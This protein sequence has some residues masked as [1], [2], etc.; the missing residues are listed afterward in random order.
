MR[1]IK[2]L[3]NLKSRVA[4]ITGAS[5]HLGRVI[6]E[7]FAELGSDL[8]IVDRHLTDLELLKDLLI[9]RYQIKITAIP[10]DLENEKERENLISKILK[11]NSQLNVFVNN[12]AFVG[13]S[14]LDG[15][16]TSFEKQ[17]IET[18][19]RAIEVNL[20][21]PFHL[22]QGLS[23]L[24]KKSVGASIIN[25]G[26]IYGELAPNWELYRDTSMSNPAAYGVSKGGLSQ[27]TRWLST[28]LA[29]E[30]RVNTIAPG[31]IYRNQPEIFVKRYENK[32][33]LKRMGKEEDF[34]GVMAFLATDMSSYMTGQILFVDGG[35]SIW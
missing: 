25:V 20:T 32:T 27:L 17:K 23:P 5:G 19:R 31:G 21:A 6:S 24:L 7:T 4:L 1:S 8:V 16:N 29:P 2:D 15:W 12:A 10:C 3:V 28:S 30:I 14:D 22:A 35:W 9:E 34:K 26:S 11:D 33:P 13:T 18:W